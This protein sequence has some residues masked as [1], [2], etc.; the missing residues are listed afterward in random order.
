MKTIGFIGGGRVT[1]ILL[2]GF[3]N[4]EI[5]FEKI[6]VYEPNETVLNALKSDYPRIEASGS[7]AT[8]GCF[9]RLGF[10]CP[11]SACSGRNPGIVESFHQNGCDGDI[12]RSK[13]HH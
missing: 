5:S 9:I 8:H 6:Q 3:K 4:A 1:R 11:A 12:A 13:N 2:Q 10:H 7:D